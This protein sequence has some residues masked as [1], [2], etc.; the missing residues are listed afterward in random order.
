MSEEPS[1]EQ[2]NSELSPAA[3]ETASHSAEMEHPKSETVHDAPIDTKDEQA[4]TSDEKAELPEAE[5]HHTITPAHT[6]TPAGERVEEEEEEASDP[7]VVEDPKEVQLNRQPL[8]EETG[9]SPA[10]EDDN[11]KAQHVADSIGMLQHTDGAHSEE[12]ESKPS[13]AFLAPLPPGSI[14]PTSTPAVEVDEMSAET[15]SSP[16]L[17]VEKVDDEL[18]HDGE[19]NWATEDGFKETLPIRSVIP[20]YVLSRA[21]SRTPE[22]AETAAEVS[23]SAAL[24]DRDRDPPTPPIS[25]EEAGRIGYSRMSS[26]PIPE[27]AK[28]AAEVA[29]VAAKLDEHPAVSA[30]YQ[31]TR[32]LG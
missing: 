24:L 31:M 32:R 28:T 7:D 29:D 4:E 22:L 11:A 23:E 2:Q 14:E 10:A 27:V 5:D 16:P 20:D 15:I 19:S 9:T 18:R 12:E 17:S 13:E 3:E 6:N 8:S 30:Y 26:T 1:A 21:E 25:D